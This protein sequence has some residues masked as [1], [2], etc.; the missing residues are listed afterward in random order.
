MKKMTF[1]TRLFG[2]GIVAVAALLAVS[3]AQ[4]FDDNETFSG[5]VTN[6][7]LESPVLDLT[8][9]TTVSNADGS[10][11]VKLTWPVVFGAGGY[12]VEVADI[13]DT[14]APVMLVDTLIDGQ[15]VSFPKTEDTNYSVRIRTLGNAKLNNK[16]AAAATD[17]LYSTWAPSQTVPAGSELS[18]YIASRIVT[19]EDLDLGQGFVL[20]AGAEYTLE[21]DLDFGLNNMVLRG[22]K[23]N[24]PT[25]RVIG[26]A[27]LVTQAGLKVKYINFDC[28]E[29]TA[30][31]LLGFS[32]SPDESIST[33]ALGFKADGANQNGYVIMQPVIFDECWVKNLPNSFIWGQKKPWSLK[34]FRITD[35]IVQ[36]DNAGSCTFL[37]LSNGSNGLIKD[38]TIRNT[39]VYNL[40]KNDSAYFI[41][42]SNASNA[43]PK[44]IFGN[45]N[46][47]SIHRIEDC[48]FAKTFSNKDFGNNIVNTNTVYQYVSNVIFY[49]VF[50]IYQ[51]LQSNNKRYTTNNVIWGVDGGTPN[52]NDTGGR[53]D[54]DGNPYATLED[55][56]FTEPFAE[57]DFTKPNGGVNFKASGALSSTIGDPRWL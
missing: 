52:G 18:A 15:S 54:S 30:T 20:E 7:Q 8:C 13:N 1:K 44:K 6:A 14:A 4:G 55:P 25:V 2:G 10:E 29:S 46:N 32:T 50:R 42:Y 28:T 41:R 22:D 57:L 53:K 37:D 51:Y 16:E 56:G 19:P 21:A 47:S 40:V 39:T 49:D 33:E 35:C 45:S 11:T 31:A 26:D 48:T 12:A 23:A 43:Q 3:C 9:F 34:D 36:L 17:Y 24:R 27:K 38:M 5:G